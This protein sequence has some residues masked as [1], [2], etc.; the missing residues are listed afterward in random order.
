LVFADQ[1]PAE[2]DQLGSVPVS[3]EAEVPDADEARRQYMQEKAAQELIGRKSHLSLLVAVR[4]ILPAEL[5]LLAI[6][7]QQTM[8]ADGDAMVYRAR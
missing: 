7:A 4:I 8:I 1:V 5:D 3:K 6:E 2:C